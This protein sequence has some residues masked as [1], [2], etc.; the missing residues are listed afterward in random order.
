MNIAGPDDGE[1]YDDNGD[2]MECDNLRI[3]NNEYIIE[4]MIILS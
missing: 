1:T 3:S 4:N 2:E